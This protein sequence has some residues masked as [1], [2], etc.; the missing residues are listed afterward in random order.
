MIKFLYY[1]VYR[2]YQKWGEKDIPEVYA[3]CFIALLQLFN[4]ITLCIIAL[5][6]HMVGVSILNKYYYFVLYFVFLALNYNYLYK[7]KGGPEVLNEM[8]GKKEVNN[9]T[10]FI[11][12]TYVIVSLASFTLAVLYYIYG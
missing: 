3:L 9:R 8:Y 10:K 5:L 7:I 12:L 1:F 4:V 2:Q 11:T 6:L